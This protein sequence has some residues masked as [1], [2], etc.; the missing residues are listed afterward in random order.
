MR[1]HRLGVVAGLAGGFVVWLYALL[2]P[3]LQQSAAAPLS[4]WLPAPLTELDPV[5]QGF[6]VGI[7]VNTLLLVVVSLLV[8]ARGADAEQA[9]AFVLGGVARGGPQPPRQT[10]ADAARIDEGCA[11]CWRDSSGRN[12]PSAPAW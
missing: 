10:P 3:T 6:V 8:R 11:S 2:L 4:G 5:G 1:A 7:A 12:A 9:H